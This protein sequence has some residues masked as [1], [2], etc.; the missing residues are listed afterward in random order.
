MT[1]EAYQIVEALLSFEPRKRSINETHEEARDVIYK[2][3]VVKDGILIC[4][5]CNNE[6]GE[7]AT[8]SD[9][10]LKTTRH[11]ECNGIIKFRPPDDETLATIERAWGIRF[12]KETNEWE[13]ITRPGAPKSD[14]DSNGE[15]DDYDE[16][17]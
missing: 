4:P 9:D 6:I 12:N 17:A 5:H 16:Y 10:D 8:F 7:K 14:E 3:R 1:I 11:R 2:D 13:P 15:P